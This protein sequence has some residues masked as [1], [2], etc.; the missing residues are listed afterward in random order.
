[1]LLEIAGE[2]KLKT[3]QWDVDTLDWKGLSANEIFERVKKS[4][5]NG[6]IVLCHNNSDHIIEAL[7]LIIN[8]LKSEGYQMVKISE[9][10]YDSDYYVDSNG[11]Q[12]QNKKQ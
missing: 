2:L 5:K 12:K 11:L 1:M 10:V 8:F 4:V 6:S 7:P 3:I 9:L